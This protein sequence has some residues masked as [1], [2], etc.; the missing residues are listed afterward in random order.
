MANKVE[1]AVVKLASA[2]YAEREDGAR[3]LTA[4]GASAYPALLRALKCGDQ[5]V[6]TYLAQIDAMKRQFL[7]LAADK[8]PEI[9]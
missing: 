9:R 2:Q 1:S 3:E 4:L 7:R 5:E 6:V 8:V